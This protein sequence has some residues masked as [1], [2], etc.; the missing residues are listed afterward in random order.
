ME[1]Q[2]NPLPLS[3]TSI[4]SIN[5]YLFETISKQIQNFKVEI[6][7]VTTSRYFLLQ[8]PHKSNASV[9]H[10]PIMGHLFHQT[11]KLLFRTAHTSHP[12]PH[13]LI[14]LSTQKK[15]STFI[16]LQQHH[17]CSYQ[18]RYTYSQKHKH[19]QNVYLFDVFSPNNT[20]NLYVNDTL[21]NNLG[22][23]SVS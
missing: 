22:A 4:N 18:Y 11:Y 23:V 12:L 2:I 10:I 1:S 5:T 9:L 16:Y 19:H 7:F 3:T 14:V 13:R 17:Q 6:K 20:Y 8:K 15:I 21:V